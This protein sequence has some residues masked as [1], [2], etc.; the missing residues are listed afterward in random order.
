MIEIDNTGERILLEKETPLMIAR[1]FCA[2]K[3]AKEFVQG[4]SVLDIGCGEGYGSDFLAGFAKEVTGIDY[5]PAVINYA[6][7]KYSKPGL[8]F[9]ILDIANLSSLN[10]KFDV[11]CSFQNI[12]HISDT[13]KLLEDIS[14]LLKDE[15]IFI[16]STCNIKDAS[17][18]SK[19]PYNKFHVKEYLIDEFKE[20][21]EK[22]FKRVEIFGLKRGVALKINRRLKK[23][24]LFNLLPARLDPVKRFFAQANCS[25]FLW[26]EKNLD[27]CLDFIAVCRR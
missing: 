23:I 12:E 16:C 7:D 24:G 15:G 2:Y 13:E 18:G 19:V 8:K 6:R 17:P 10:R 1:H 26:S 20:M 25:Y 14:S 22:Y 27:N 21:L 3:F 9:S 11:I 5:D 4:K